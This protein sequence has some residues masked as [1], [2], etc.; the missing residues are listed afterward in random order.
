MDTV[1]DPSSVNFKMSRFLAVWFAWT[2]GSYLACAAAIVAAF[3]II[4]VL[5]L[6][7]DHW[8]GLIF[9]VLFGVSLGGIQAMILSRRV[10]RSAWWIP[11]TVA[12]WVAIL[13]IVWLM[14][15]VIP[16]GAMD[17]SGSMITLVITGATTGFS[18]WLFLRPYWRHAGW[19]I[20]ASILGGLALA[21]AFGPVITSMYELSLIGLIPSACTGLAV[22]SLFAD[23]QMAE[24]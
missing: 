12:G 5:S 23:P 7:E 3:G 24:R 22:A 17:D 8:F 21:L 18:Q 19:W 14:S 11:A 13:P 20:P 15:L 1:S 2:L 9:V 4:R 10:S 6:N 16:E